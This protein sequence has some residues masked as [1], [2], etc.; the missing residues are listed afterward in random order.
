V[1]YI[2]MREEVSM[3]VG[4]LNSVLKCREFHITTQDHLEEQV[5]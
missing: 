1:L 5:I 3:K 4:D 2:N